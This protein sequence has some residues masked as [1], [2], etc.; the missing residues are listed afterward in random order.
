MFFLALLVLLLHFELASST[1]KPS[2]FVLSSCSN[3]LLYIQQLF[4]YWYMIIWGFNCWDFNMIHILFYKMDLYKYVSYIICNNVIYNATYLL[5]R[6][7]S[8]R[9]QLLMFLIIHMC[10]VRWTSIANGIVI[11]YESNK[12]WVKRLL[13]QFGDCFKMPVFVL[14]IFK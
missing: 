7:S 8:K 10:N 13:V 11:Y 6:R 2:V 5:F 12:L 14:N 3:H 9:A 1:N 4:Y